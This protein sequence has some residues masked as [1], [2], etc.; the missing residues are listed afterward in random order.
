MAEFTANQPIIPDGAPS[1]GDQD[2]ISFDGMEIHNT[3]KKVTLNLGGAAGGDLE[4]RVSGG[5][6]GMLAS[7]SSGTVTFGGGT[8]IFQ[9]SS[10]SDPTNLQVYSGR[11]AI[12]DLSGDLDNNGT[13]DTVIFMR[14]NNAGVV[15][16]AVD[17]DDPT[18]FY[19]DMGNVS[20][21]AN[22]A[23]K[24]NSD[25]SIEVNQ[26]Q[27][28]SGDLIWYDQSGEA[29]R[30]D[31]TNGRLGLGI[32]NPNA[33]LTIESETNVQALQATRNTTNTTGFQSAVNI[34]ANTNGNMST[35]NFGVGMFA[36]VE[37]NTSGLQFIGGITWSTDGAD[38]FGQVN[39]QGGEDGNTVL[40]NVRQNGLTTINPQSNS[41]GD[42]IWNRNGSL[43]AIFDASTGYVS[44][45]TPV[46]D[47][48]FRLNVVGDLGSNA[49]LFI[50][51]T[52]N[53][54]GANSAIALVGRSTGDAGNGF[55][56]GFFAFLE[57]NG[58]GARQGLG[59]VI[60]VRDG[61][62]NEGALNLYTGTDAND[63]AMTINKDGLSTM[64][65]SQ[66]AEGD[67]VWN[68]DSA[69]GVL[70]DATN[71]EVFL[72]LPTSAGTAGSLWNDSGTVKVA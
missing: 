1:S 16:L 22:T 18:S 15:S 46:D 34:I 13:D 24:F 49:A 7:A 19:I 66:D 9:A 12:L 21:G 2:M 50:R 70:F 26:Q 61:D 39:L 37:D 65:A 59:G 56:T 71:G 4:W 29:G 55:G 35:T 5:T 58:T 31:A 14:N 63:L 64:N 52:N 8:G 27:S 68:K 45:N 40:L 48:D 6:V 67:F 3:T 72:N 17:G 51:E 43:G 60:F 54:T 20:P 30:F 33:R 25:L 69:Q 38:D 10:L 41:G 57:D 28:A 36:G 44:I 42:L 32:S 53:T 23:M 62:D 11:Q 47:R